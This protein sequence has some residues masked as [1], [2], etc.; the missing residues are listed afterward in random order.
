[1]AAKR[2][3][4]WTIVVAL[5]PLSA[6]ADE[7]TQADYTDPTDR[8]AHGVL[9]DAI[10]WGGLRLTLSDG[11]SKRFILSKELVFEDIAPRLHDLDQ[12][13]APEV[14]VVLTHVD[15]GA[16]LAVF[17]STGLIAQ[18]P[19]IGT[20]NRW[21]APVGAGD[22]LGDGDQIVAYVDRPHLAKTLRL[23]R[24][25]EGQLT[26]VANLT[27]LTNHRIGDNFI[28]GGIRNCGTGDEVVTVD[29]K[30]QNVM[31]TTFADVPPSSREVLPY[32]GE[33]AVERVLACEN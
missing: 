32:T 19:H 31:V 2:R 11:S 12:D 29:A 8:Y 25:H 24:Y 10:E 21:L 30:W 4:F 16:A 18:T 17:G 23:W 1:M 27:G 7:I 3:G 33:D 13:G 26:E 20:R 5:L 9:G 6:L 14:I 28:T 22:L 15:K